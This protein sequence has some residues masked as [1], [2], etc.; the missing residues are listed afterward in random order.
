MRTG[1]VSC[2]LIWQ[3]GIGFSLLPKR[4]KTL[5]LNL[6]QITHTKMQM[7]KECDCM[8]LFT[9]PLHHLYYQVTLSLEFE[10]MHVV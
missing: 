2:R 5:I 4:C 3:N 8:L 10:I 6:P 9:G 1:L 7:K